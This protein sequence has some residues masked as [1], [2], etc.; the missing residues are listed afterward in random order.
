MQNYKY[1]GARGIRVCAEWHDFEK[2]SA[3]AYS[4]GYMDGLSIDRIDSS[5]N[6][7][8]GNCQWISTADNTQ[9]AMER[10]ISV[11]GVEGNLRAWAKLLGVSTSTISY[12]MN[13]LGIHVGDWIKSRVNKQSKQGQGLAA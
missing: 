12:H 1:Y 4:N 8:P 10:I 6:Y 3:W 5:K 11:D 2:F 13:G 7:Q 9:K